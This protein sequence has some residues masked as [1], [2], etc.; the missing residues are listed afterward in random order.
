MLLKIE[1]CESVVL[2][3]GLII[4]VIN[5][6]HVDGQ[7]HRI[8][9]DTDVD[10]DDVL[11]ILYILKLDRSIFDLRAITINTNS[12]TNAGH[13]VNQ[14]YDLLYMMGR[15]DIRVGVGGDGGIFDN[16]TISS[17]VGGYLPII[18]Q[19]YGTTGY[20][21]YSQV[22]PLGM[23]G[24]LDID[25]KYGYTKS[26]L[27]QGYRRYVPLEQPTTQQVMID[28][29][30]AGPTTIFVTGP[31]TNLAIFLMTSPQL[32]KNI[33]AIYILGGGLRPRTAN[34][35]TSSLSCPTGNVYTGDNTAPDA[36]YNIFTDPFAA[37]QVIH[38]GIKIILVPLDATDTMP[39]TPEFL[40]EFEKNQQ[41]FEAQFCF[42]NLKM[43]RDTWF[44]D[45]FSTIFFMWDSFLTGIATSIM[46]KHNNPNGCNEFAEMEYKN[47]TVVTSNKPYGIS[48]SS[49]PFFDNRE[50]S[51]FKLT[52]KGVHSGHV[53]TGLGD[54]FCI[55]RNGCKDGYT[56]E[57]TDPEGV[58]VL[59]AMRAKPNPDKTSKLKKAFY[60]QFLDVMNR[61]HQTGK[62]NYDKQFPQYHQVTNIP[63]FKGRK[64][65]K[66]VVFDM[67]MS[68]G[69]ILALIYLLKVPVEELYLK[70]IIVTPTGWANAATIN[71]IYDLLH[72]MK[73]DDILVGL[74]D[75]YATNQ[76]YPYFPSIGR[77]K[78]RRAIPHGA[79]G[80]LDSDTL[81]GFAHCLIRSPRRYTS[82]NSVKHGAPRD[83]EHPELRQPLALEVWNSVIKS[84]DI[85]SRVTI[86][87]NGPLT[88]LAQIIQLDKS[89]S[90]H[91]Q[92]I[93]V[94]GGH[95]RGQYFNEY[96]QG[97]VMNIDCNKY[98]ELNM[99]LD[100]LAAKIVF[101][102]SLNITLI[103]LNVQR[104]VTGY[105]SW[106]LSALETQGT[107]EA[108]FARDLLSTL[109]TLKRAHSI[110]RHVDMF[111][112]EIL[113]SVVLAGN[114]LFPIRT[115]YLEKN[116]KVLATGDE[117]TDGQMINTIKG[118][119]SAVRIL[120]W[121]SPAAFAD[122]FANRLGD[123]EQSSGIPS[124][125]NI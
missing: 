7:P 43:I 90:S 76:T 84:L 99:F 116:I 15:D 45:N 82:E 92:E 9:F 25:T 65:G 5:M 97:N 20:C 47:I 23:K 77:C 39:I 26:F 10:V 75:L 24:R 37:Y 95:L 123:K 1:K 60:K 108:A 8:L 66:L 52:K 29:I 125:F 64:L 96:D 120:A 11:A 124:F 109:V 30:S 69:D 107:P 80:F 27:P 94:V 53:I 101:E 98:A 28:T 49:N 72:I 32:K 113:G 2:A 103:P 61:Q 48:D 121:A 34:C 88:S 35:P 41:T 93:I 106:A 110:Y 50:K 59:V 44:T 91:I 54:P 89:L 70:A 51:K 58:R 63:D 12:W 13:A 42:K 36:E 118:K 21:R 4:I 22:I 114:V 6:Y 105:Y 17:N 55:A 104:M 102:A 119:G 38:S 56:P 100:P 16:S 71:V 57:V 117:C 33:E 85:G 73:R 87:T 111:Y 19:D 3:I 122:T 62:F 40:E 83:T 115:M 68:P 18:D 46:L 86:L 74:G 14:V 79:G 81:Y 112:G 31:A 67:D 78:Y